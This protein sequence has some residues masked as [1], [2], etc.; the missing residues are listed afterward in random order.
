MMNGLK[1]ESTA[2]TISLNAN[3]LVINT[4]PFHSLPADVVFFNG[5][6][7]FAR[8][9]AKSWQ[10]NIAE[11]PRLKAISENLSL[12]KPIF[13]ITPPEDLSHFEPNR[14]ESRWLGKFVLF[15][16]TDQ[17]RDI[18]HQHSPNPIITFQ[19]NPMI[20]I[21]LRKQILQLWN[22][23][24]VKPVAS[25]FGERFAATMLAQIADSLG[26]EDR[27]VF[28]HEDRLVAHANF[29]D[30]TMPL[31]NLTVTA[32]DELVDPTLPKQIRV[33]IHRVVFECLRLRKNR[34]IHASILLNNTNSLQHFIKNGFYCAAVSFRELESQVVPTR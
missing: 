11:L 16:Q 27:Y 3:G 19:K 28:W 15:T 6:R 30:M 24:F 26:D 12:S 23:H 33:A 1:I 8:L 10:A 31:I 32:I 7:V 21:E 17:L 14:E 25:Y 9:S 29:C 34:V 13:Y 22:C 20:G 4:H 2:A 5:N 18:P